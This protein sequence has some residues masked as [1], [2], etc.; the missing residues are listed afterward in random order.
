V[1]AL[2][3]SPRVA[4]TGG[5]GFIGSH[6]VDALLER[7]AKVLVVDDLSTGRRENVAEGAELAELDIREADA[8]RR[9]FADFGANSVC[10][11]AAQASV[12][13]SVREPAVDLAVNAVGTFNVCE[14]ARAL[15]ASVVFA[16]TGGA[17]YGDD[18]ELPTPESTIPRPLSP[19]GASKL[20][21]EAYVGTWGRLHG[22]PNVV[23][24][25]ANIYGPRQLP[26]TEAGVVAIFSGKLAGGEAPTIYGDGKQT[27]D[28]T[29]VAD[30][31]AAFVAA[32]ESGRAGT[33]NVGTGKETTVLELLE[34]LQRAAGTSLEPRFEPL[35]PGELLRSA[36]DAGLIESELEWR[37]RI[38]LAEGLA[39]TY[40]TYAG[41]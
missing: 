22:L 18:A 13:F 17:L 36:L 2:S 4:V 40:L 19:Y 3:G 30:V 8:L 26:H 23:L 16:S 21:G 32:L 5:A 37:P 9:A 38:D 31:A 10:H 24:R 1:A 6:V 27:R 11:L 12:T 7:E 29:H 41:Y 39:A 28:Y 33:Y 14:A 20:A 35:R 25:L 34:H 15:G